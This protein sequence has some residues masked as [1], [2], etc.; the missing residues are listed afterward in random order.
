VHRD[1]KPANLL[2]AGDLP[3]RP[4]VYLTDFGLARRDGSS[5]ALTTTGQWM[6][7]PDYAAPE[8]IDGY[9]LDARSDVYALGCVLFAALTG[10]PPFGDRPR[11]AKAA[12]HVHETPPTLRSR[13][14]SAPLALEPVIA[15]AL[16]KRPED[17][18]QSA[19]ELGAAALAAAQAPG[20]TPRT[21]R[22]RRQARSLP[23]ARLA[24]RGARRPI[25][26]AVLG[27]LALVVAGLVIAATLGAFSSGGHR[28]A[29]AAASPPA[30]PPAADPALATVRC[31]STS[32]TQRGARVVTPIEGSAC[33]PGGRAGEWK[34]IDADGQ[35][36]LFGCVPADSPPAGA[37]PLA[38]VPDLAGARLDHA[39]ELLDRFGV[40][41]D[42]SGGGT[43]G[44]IDSGNWTVCTT[45]PGA[46]SAL[47]ADASVKLY[48]DRSC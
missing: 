27:A 15:R 17:R 10:T 4:H 19:G 23:T 40:H 47:A 28:A 38:T 18:Y 6:G 14:A 35:N 25:S 39:E 31:S 46:G 41:H 32:C 8:Q 9:D 43:F 29:P 5:G 24:S 48:V 34:R 45:T 2:V 37:A 13:R 22:L 33:R 44:I 7:T 42:T 30:P 21:R 20:A 1:V 26:L 36:P 11:M 12:A 3:S 16:A